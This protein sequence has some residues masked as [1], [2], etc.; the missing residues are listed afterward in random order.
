MLDQRRDLGRDN[1]FRKPQRCVHASFF[2]YLASPAAADCRAHKI[3]SGQC[4]TQTLDQ[5]LPH[6]AG[7]IRAVKQTG[8]DLRV[9]AEPLGD[10]PQRN[11]RQRHVR[12]VKH[13]GH[14]CSLSDL[15]DCGRNRY[16]NLAAERHEPL[17][18]R[19][20]TGNDLDQIIV[21]QHR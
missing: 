6:V 1:R 11:P 13:V 14:G 9:I 12:I 20:S 3:R 2:G 17:Q 10:P 5:R 15:G 4:R 18:R 8:P 21:A 7:Q 19:P 16:G